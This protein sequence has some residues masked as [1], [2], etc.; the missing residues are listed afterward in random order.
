MIPSFTCTGDSLLELLDWRLA[1]VYFSTN[2]LLLSFWTCFWLTSLMTGISL[3][4]YAHIK[5][6]HSIGMY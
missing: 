4:R 5:G 1:Y 2:V 6:E 3:R